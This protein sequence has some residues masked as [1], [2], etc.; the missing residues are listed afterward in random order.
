[1]CA[2]RVSQITFNVCVVVNSIPDHNYWLFWANVCQHISD[3]LRDLL[4]EVIYNITLLSYKVVIIIA[5]AWIHLYLSNWYTPTLRTHI[6]IITSQYPFRTQTN[7]FVAWYQNTHLAATLQRVRLIL[8]L[9]QQ[10]GSSFTLGTFSK[11]ARQ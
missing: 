1:M 8:L 3:I 10:S 11:D 7:N 4:Q 9:M 5:Y 6:L 2:K